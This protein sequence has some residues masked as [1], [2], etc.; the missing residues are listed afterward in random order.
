M[1]CISCDLVGEDLLFAIEDV[2]LECYRDPT[3]NCCCECGKYLSGIPY[4]YICGPCI[5]RKKDESK[6]ISD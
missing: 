3:E 4:E 6:E 5:K 1:K 2:C